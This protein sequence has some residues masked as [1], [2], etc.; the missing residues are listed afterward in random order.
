MEFVNREDFRQWLSDHCLSVDD[1]W[2]LF[3]K[4]GGSKT[5]KACEALE[6]ALY[7]GWING[8]MQDIDDITY[9]KHFSMRREK[10]KWSEKTRRWQRNLKNREL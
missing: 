8:H 10:S 7:F 1:I 2:L 3:D 5:I 4:S 6:E 9:K